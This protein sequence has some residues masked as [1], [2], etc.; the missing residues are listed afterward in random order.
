[1]GKEIACS[2]LLAM[3]PDRRRALCLTRTV[4]VADGASLPLHL[5]AW[6]MTE[7]GAL[8][9]D[10]GQCLRHMML[11]TTDTMGTA[12]HMRVKDLRKLWIKLLGWVGKNIDDGCWHSAQGALIKRRVP[13]GEV[14]CSSS[15][16]TSLLLLAVLDA[17]LNRR[18]KCFRRS[19]E[20]LMRAFFESV[21]CP[22]VATGAVDA[23][24]V[25]HE[26]YMGV[27]GV[28]NDHSGACAHI[29]ELFAYK[30]LGGVGFAKGRVVGW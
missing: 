4:V 2:T 10:I 17:A 25:W 24:S 8:R 13:S 28:L 19:I 30:P 16:S 5:K 6:S 23:C 15:M 7:D 1:M 21:V 27:C 12:T 3:S 20:T 26:R 14:D 29:R 18:R 9:W 22:S 11:Y